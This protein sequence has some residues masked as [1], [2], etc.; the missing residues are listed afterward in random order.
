MKKVA[1]T[2]PESTG[3]TSLARQL[4][5][6]FN[7][8][9]V[10]EYA[11]T[12]LS[13]INR[14]YTKDDILFIAKQQVFSEH[15][16]AS[17]ANKVLFS[18]TE[19]L[20]TKIWSEVKFGT[21]P[22]WIDFQIKQQDYDLYLLMDVDVQWVADP[23]REHPNWEQR[24]HL[25]YLYQQALEQLGVNYVVISGN[26]QERLQ[27]ATLEVKKIIPKPL[28]FKKHPSKSVYSL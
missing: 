8:T 27:K 4:A 11:R 17:K 14:P 13:R 24:Q 28:R 7:T 22:T 15:Q 2:G 12:H 19:L 18:D 20:V 6:N 9:W 10:P 3:K 1:I 16:Y 26:Y 23:L 5:N 21:C 25:F